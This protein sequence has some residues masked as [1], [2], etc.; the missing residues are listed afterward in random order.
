MIANLGVIYVAFFGQPRC[1]VAH[2]TVTVLD[3]EDRFLRKQFSIFICYIN[4]IYFNITTLC[5]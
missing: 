2:F 5:V 1:S 3:S 4:K